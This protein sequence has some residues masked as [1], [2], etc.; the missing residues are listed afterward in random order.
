[1]KNFKFIPIMLA[2][3]AACVLMYEVVDAAEGTGSKYEPFV[4]NSTAYNNPNGNPTFSG[5]PTVEGITIAGR[6]E[7]L[8]CVAALY[9]INDDGT[10]GRFIGYREFTDTGY[11]V[12]STQYPG[13]GTIQT[14]ETVDLYFSDYEV[15]KK[16]GEKKIWI[17]VIRGKG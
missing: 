17:Q 15:C 14:G 2:A 3:V 7:W 9:E 8:G 1:M 4:V 16:W 5:K 13:L 12:D 11:G 10:I 6:A